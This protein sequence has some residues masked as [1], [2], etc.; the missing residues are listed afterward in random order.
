MN[1][2]V[3]GVLAI[4]FVLSVQWVSAG[5]VQIN[6]G[7]IK[8]NVLAIVPPDKDD[9]EYGEHVIYKIVFVKEIE[10]DKVQILAPTPQRTTTHWID[11]NSIEITTRTIPFNDPQWGRADFAPLLNN[12]RS[13]IYTLPRLQHEVGSSEPFYIFNVRRNKLCRIQLR[14]A[15]PCLKTSAGVL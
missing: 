7:R 8:S 5:P 15:T 1:R 11:K 12:E 3:Y 10:K 4:T 14:S 13:I 2:L 9:T 6:I